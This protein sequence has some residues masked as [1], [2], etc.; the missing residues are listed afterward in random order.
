MLEARRSR[1]TALA[2]VGCRLSRASAAHSGLRLAV[3]GLTTPCR[4]EILSG[5]RCLAHSP[6]TLC[7]FVSAGTR[8]DCALSGSGNLFFRRS[9]FF[10]L[11]CIN[12]IGL[13]RYR[14]MVL[15]GEG[16]SLFEIKDKGGAILHRID[17]RRLDKANLAGLVLR[18]ANLAGLSLTRAVLRRRTCAKRIYLSPT[19][20]RP[21]SKKRFSCA[22]IDSRHADRR[23]A[24]RLRPARGQSTARQH[25]SGKPER[26]GASEP[27]CWGPTCRAST[28]RTPI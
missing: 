9:N 27:A 2:R 24:G 22:R 16:T 1:G 3:P 21:I 12:S 17:A 25:V 20:H 13:W 4:G 26:H 19:W 7:L 8:H 10:H 14:S 23:F 6:P 11:Q 18:C 15:P 28:S 5:C